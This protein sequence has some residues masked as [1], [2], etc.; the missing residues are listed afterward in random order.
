MIDQRLGDSLG[1]HLE[2]TLLRPELPTRLRSASR[3]K[4]M[5]VTSKRNQLKNNR[6][7]A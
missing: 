5:R 1:N 6:P 7:I 4:T 2:L 3:I